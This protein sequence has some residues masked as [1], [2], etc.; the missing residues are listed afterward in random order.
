MPKRIDW[1]DRVEAIREVTYE[2]A[3]EHGISAI[4]LPAVAERLV[5]S[6]RTVQRLVPSERALPHLALQRAERLERN[7]LVHR[8]RVP[9]WRSVPIP[10]RSLAM[11]LEKLPGQADLPDRD[12]WWQLVLAHAG[13]DWARAARAVCDD[14]VARAATDAMSGIVDDDAR[15]RE[16]IRLHSLV[17]GAGSLICDGRA[18]YGQ[19]EQIVRGH[20]AQVLAEHRATDHDAA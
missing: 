2:I 16:V 18:T 3:I 7:R 17:V 19:V 20:V 9:S 5:M 15:A 1:A 4:S 12:V 10:E 13:T 11:L 14:E 6:P 8:S